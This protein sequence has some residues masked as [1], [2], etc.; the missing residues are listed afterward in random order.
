MS[1]LA[2]RLGPLGIFLLM[3]PE[4]A[5]LPVPS[6]LTLMSAGFGVHEGWFSLPVAVAVATAGN[7]VGSTI[8]YSMGRLGVL[9]KLSTGG[10][11]G[12]GIAVSKAGD[13]TFQRRRPRA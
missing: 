11:R 1:W 9:T 12:I 2:G 10:R 5:C 4:S 7:L 8:A 13:A 3:I 6:E